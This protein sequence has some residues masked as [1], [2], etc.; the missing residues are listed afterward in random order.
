VHPQFALPTEQVDPTRIP[1]SNERLVPANGAP[2]SAAGSR[3]SCPSSPDG[4]AQ[5][6]VRIRTDRGALGPTR[7][8]K[9]ALKTESFLTH[10]YTIGVDPQG[11]VVLPGRFKGTMD[12]GDGPV[13]GAL[14][15]FFVKYRSDGSFAY[16][17]I[18]PLSIPPNQCLAPSVGGNVDR[19]GGVLLVGDMPMRGAVDLGGGL[20]SQSAGTCSPADGAKFFF[21]RYAP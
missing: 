16:K 21:S 6:A 20:G 15:P 19:N 2:V 11:D 7:S 17:R 8:A 3:V 4:G 18:F 12:F 14:D 13:V 9:T 10:T 5:V 1:V